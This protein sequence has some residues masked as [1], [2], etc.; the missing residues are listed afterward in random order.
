MN[1]MFKTT[2]AKIMEM[3][4]C[5]NSSDDCADCVTELNLIDHVHR[6]NNTIFMFVFLH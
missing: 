1:V 2:M 6:K 4:L 5:C 3:C